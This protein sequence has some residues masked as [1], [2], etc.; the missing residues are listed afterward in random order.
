MLKKILKNGSVK[1]I[2]L[3][4]GAVLILLFLLDFVILP[5]WVNKAETKVPNVVGMYE[6]DAINLLEN[7]D[8][9]PIISDTT[10]NQNFPKGTIALQ[11]P[12]PGSVVKVGRRVYLFL[13]GGEPTVIVPKLIGKSVRDAKFALERIGLV[14]GEVELVPSNTPKNMIFDQEYFEGTPLK[15]GQAVKVFV[16]SGIESGVITVPDLIGRSLMEAS[17]ILADSS[18]QVGKINYQISFTLLPNTVIDQYPS[19]DSKLNPGD[20]VDLFVTKAADESI[21]NEIEER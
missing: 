3:T 1:K 21:K 6:Q 4:F 19:K 16:S 10:F 15:K 14:L 13:S 2:L 20:A 11:K 12:D 18:L 9:N 17:K 8:L 7:N 5:W